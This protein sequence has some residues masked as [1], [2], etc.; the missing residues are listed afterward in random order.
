[1]IPEYADAN[2]MWLAMIED[3]LSNGHELQ[4]RVGKCFE[5]SG[6]SGKIS[7]ANANLVSS[8]V[9]KLSATYAG[10]EVLWYLG[11]TSNIEMI[12]AYAPSYRRLW[13]DKIDGS[14]SGME[15]F[16][17]VGGRLRSNPGYVSL[18]ESNARDKLPSSQL[19]A[20]ALLL[21]HAPTTRQC[22]ISLW[23]SQD[24]GLAILGTKKNVPCYVAFQFLLRDGRLSM[25]TTM[26]SNDVWLGA[27]YDIFAFCC[28]LRLLADCI[29]AQVG[30]YTHNV[31]SLH[32]YN[33]HRKRCKRALSDQT[34]SI[35]VEPLTWLAE[36]YE[37]AGQLPS[38]VA[39]PA[40]ALENAVRRGMSYPQ[41][42]S[43]SV[44]RTWFDEARDNI[45]AWGGTMLGDMLACALSKWTP[46]PLVDSVAHRPLRLALEAEYT[47]GKA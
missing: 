31:G 33:K 5:V 35:Y 20:A 22:V 32:V 25:V 6:W 46:K 23:D 41:Q 17:A 30:S 47:N 19:D 26:R 15:M 42:E 14:L 10:A 34:P 8:P 40:I 24:L 11:L 16:G 18:L 13:A 2:A 4:S 39:A 1:M 44:P 28:I 36:P 12:E 37:P 38:S 29:G 9:R 45:H 3:C 21:Q 43:D 7:D 27:P